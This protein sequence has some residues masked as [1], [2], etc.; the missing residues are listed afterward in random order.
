MKATALTIMLAAL[1]PAAH[2]ADYPADTPVRG[3]TIVP[4]GHS[5]G[6]ERLR[7][8]EAM[9]M[10][11]CERAAKDNLVEIMTA[12]DPMDDGVIFICMPVAF[13]DLPDTANVPL[14]QYRK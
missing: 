10:E 1:S 9:T 13:S 14:W 11:E 2:A 3:V 5:L 8:S 12:R 4:E 7:L 6:G